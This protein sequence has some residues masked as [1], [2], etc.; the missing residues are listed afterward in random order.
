MLG[1]LPVLHGGIASKG[2]L[3]LKDLYSVQDLYCCTLSVHISSLKWMTI[4]YSFPNI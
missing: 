4:F 2:N 3:V 1:D